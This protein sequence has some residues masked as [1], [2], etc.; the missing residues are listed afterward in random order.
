MPSLMGRDRE[1]REV[2]RVSGR[3]G[4]GE[5]RREREREG[6]KE[7]DREGVGDREREMRRGG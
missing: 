2:K 5:G 7:R 1:R 6:G 4:R 3:R